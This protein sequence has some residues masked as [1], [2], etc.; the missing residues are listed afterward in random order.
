M[1][2][3]A[4]DV[5]T[6]TRYPNSLCQISLILVS[7]PPISLFTTLV[8]PPENRFDDFIIG[9]HG[10]T[11]EMTKNSPTLEKV[12]PIILD[13]LSGAKLIAH[14]AS[15]D[16]NV[17]R[18]SLEFYNIDF[19]EFN[20]EC[21]YKATSLKLLEACKAN[22]VDLDNHH[23]S[24][25]DALACAKLYMRLNNI[26]FPKVSSDSRDFEVLKKRRLQGDVLKKDL[27]NADSN[28]Y[29]YDKKVVFT[30]VLSSIE[31]KDAAAIVKQMGAD[32]DTSITKRT[33]YVICGEG[34][35]PSKMRKIEKYNT[36]GSDIQKVD[37][38]TF[39]KILKDE[40]IQIN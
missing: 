26:Q 18:K 2:L 28:S 1:R 15:F 10:I 17:I 39:L 7:D 4:I 6:A 11:P 35:G 33:K 32:V 27:S 34:V 5:E 20:W 36:Q 22:K 31:R 29:F 38:V 25:F 30:G 12:W 19:P 21:T 23:D 24:A 37:E 40:G 14:N 3:V 13:Q 9:I 16:R 8:Q